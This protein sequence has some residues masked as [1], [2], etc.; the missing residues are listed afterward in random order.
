MIVCKTCYNNIIG[1]GIVTQCDLLP[2]WP[3][4]LRDFTTNRDVFAFAGTSVVKS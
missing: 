1:G 4:L 3:A 2:A